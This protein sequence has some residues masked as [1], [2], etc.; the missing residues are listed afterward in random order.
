M[1]AAAELLDRARQLQRQGDWPQAERLCRQLIE[2]HP[3]SA[4]AWDLLASALLNRGQAAEAVAASRQVVRL[5]PDSA[6]ANYNLGL[7][8]LR[9]GQR[10]EALDVFGQAVRLKPDHVEALIQFGVGLAERGAVQ[11]GLPHLREAVRVRPQHPPGHHNLGVALAQSGQL[12]EAAAALE[13]ALRLRPDYAEAHFNLGNVLGSLE[14]REEAIRHYWRALELRPDHTGAYNNLGLALTEVKRAGEAVVLLQQAVR[15]Q[16]DNVDAH[17]NLGLAWAALGRFAEAEAAFAQVLRLNPRHAEAHANLGSTMK[18]QG[19]LE[20]ALASYRIALLFDPESVSTHYNRGLALLHKGDYSQGWTEYEWRWRRKRTPPR[21]FRQ[22]RWDGS[23]L[24]GKT[25]LLYM[26]Q[27]LGDMIQFI[28]F[29]ALVK[30]KG[31]RVVVEC[32]WFFVPLFSTCAG[33]DQVVAEGQPLPDFD[34]HAPLMSLPFLLGNTAEPVPATIPYLSAPP[35]REASWKE[36]LAEV[37]GFKVGIVWQGNPYFEWDHWRSIPLRRFAPLAAVEGVSL[38]SLQRVHG[39]D[40]LRSPG[41][42][43]EVRELPAQP[44]EGGFLDTAAI[45]RNL[46]L[47]VTVDTAVGHLA[48][49]LGVPAWVAVGAVSDWRWLRGRT[50]SPWYP[51]HRL[52]RQE[53][54]GEWEPVLGRMA[55]ELAGAVKAGDRQRTA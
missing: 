41:P 34:V 47:V 22:P 42:G 7:A 54:L 48:G 55:S 43:F 29:A 1:P 14:R 39:L 3:G 36:Q 16:P 10:E 6:D 28:R 40:Q 4:D 27:G 19:R 52:F 23:S 9:Q 11:E 45:L 21:P 35:E 32:P 18:E 26:E 44:D 15:L 33:I 30:A 37:P 12:E 5:K 50:D 13:E 53:K 20:E 46:D 31:G 8:L 17:N 25:I 38:V 51:R 2:M 24:E 49:A